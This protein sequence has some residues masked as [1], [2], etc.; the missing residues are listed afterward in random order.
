MDNLHN[1]SSNSL[2]RTNRIVLIINWV[3]NLI[4]I[5]GYIMEFLKGNRSL[6]YVGTMLSL[7]IVTFSLATIVYFR[8]SS[9]IKIK[10]LTLS[11]YFI[12]YGFSLMTSDRFAVFTYLFPILLMYFLYF[13]FKLIIWAS[14]ISITLNLISML[15]NILILKLIN[16]SLSTDYTIQLCVVIMYCISLTLSSILAI[17][18]NNEKI[19]SIE[20]E[21]K[22]QKEILDDVLKIAAVLD[23][24][25]KKVYNIM[26]DFNSSTQDVYNSV[27]EI[28]KSTAETAESFKVQSSLT[29]DIHKI[30]E[31]SSEVSSKTSILS[32]DTSCAI[33][34]GMNIVNDLSNMSK[35]VNENNS[36][37]NNIINELKT[38]ATEILN[39]TDIIK[40]ISEQTN[41]LSLNAA[42][43]SARAGESGKG[44][45]VVAE[46]VRK[47]ATQSAESASSINKIIIEL[48]NMTDTSVIAISE[49]IDANQKQNNLIYKTQEL[50]NS[51]LS[52]ITEVNN[53]VLLVNERIDHILNANNKIVDCIQEASN[54]SQLASSNANQVNSTVDHNME[55]ANL[56]KSLVTEL[57]TTSKQM[58]KYIGS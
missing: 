49:L 36:N 5:V 47:L 11:A 34:E 26:D 58:E 35:V 44:F 10:Y 41:M 3:I 7:I 13:D 2:K 37:M 19:S 22:R 33:K 12:I 4:L 43:E 38:K 28:A 53:N 30:I 24:N 16:Q 54:L 42:I 46:E 9:S 8:N 14:S 29:H 18:F 55:N 48:N 21:K 27:T 31:E 50:F 32:K 39:I 56:A 1:I 15:K 57:I 17:R 40:S 6:A 45:A 20:G 23:T 51:T 52:K 25:S